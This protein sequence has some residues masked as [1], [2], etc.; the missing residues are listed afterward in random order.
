VG[1][2]S[3]E[4]EGGL[5][6]CCCCCLDF[7]KAF[8]A[9]G[10]LD[11]QDEVQFTNLVFTRHPKSIDTWAYQ[12]VYGQG[13]GHVHCWTLTMVSCCCRRGLAVRLCGSLS[14]DALREFFEQQIEVCSRL[15]ELKTR[16]YH[17]RGFHN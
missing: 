6:T 8:V 12:C 15:A 3:A 9:N 16:N 4:V 17:A 1:R 11:I 10:W 7:S 13:L 5:L 2:Q 14:G